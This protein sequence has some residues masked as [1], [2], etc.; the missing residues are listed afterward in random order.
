MECTGI[1]KLERKNKDETIVVTFDCQDE[2][3][4]EMTEEQMEHS[5]QDAGEEK[6]EEIGTGINFTV[7]IDKSGNKMIASCTAGVDVQV[8]EVRYVPTGKDP[9]DEDLYAGPVFHE[10]DEELQDSFYTYLADRKVDQDLAFFVV[11]HSQNK[12]QKEYVNWLNKLVD[13]TSK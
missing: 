6:G 11:A 7:S 3:E 12:E 4:M 1:V 10:L 9:D 8:N 2:E 5:L 13:F